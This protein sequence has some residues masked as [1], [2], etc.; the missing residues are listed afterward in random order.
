MTTDYTYQFVIPTYV[1][2]KYRLA[3]FINDNNLTDFCKM[4]ILKEPMHVC[5]NMYALYECELT[6]TSVV[7]KCI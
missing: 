2:L 1:P 5:K 3:V 4:C 6:R 7:R